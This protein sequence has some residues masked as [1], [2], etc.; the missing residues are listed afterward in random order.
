MVEQLKQAE[1]YLSYLEKYPNVILD[2]DSNLSDV[3]QLIKKMKQA[4]LL[5]FDSIIPTISY[6]LNRQISSSDTFVCDVL[7]FSY[8]HQEYKYYYFVRTKQQDMVKEQLKQFSN[9]LLDEN[10]STFELFESFEALSLVYGIT[11][12]ILSQVNYLCLAEHV[13]LVE[14]EQPAILYSKHKL[15]RQIC[16]QIIQGTFVEMTDDTLDAL[17]FIDNQMVL[18]TL[19]LDAH[20]KIISLAK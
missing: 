14:G 2:Y 18:D 4:F 3:K 7:S 9:L 8:Y 10:K 1:G 6:F 13:S 15:F 16:W 19:L 11:M 5:S 12:T 20:R 17:H